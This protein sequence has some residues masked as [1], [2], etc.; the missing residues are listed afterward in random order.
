MSKSE[1]GDIGSKVVL[2]A[3]G[4]RIDQVRELSD[5][6]LGN[7]QRATDSGLQLAA[8]LTRCADAAEAAHLYRAWV[9]EC[10]DR[11]FA[12]GRVAGE[13]WLKLCRTEADLLMS[14]VS[15][16]VPRGPGALAAE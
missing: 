6:W 16:S 3:C 10:R 8:Q 2:D 14:A 11:L 9:N 1:I 15:Q 5:L 13:L 7:V 4:R 12:D